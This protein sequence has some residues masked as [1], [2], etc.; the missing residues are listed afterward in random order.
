MRGARM[1]SVQTLP[2]IPDRRH[3]FT[4]AA[5]SSGSSNCDPI[6][7]LSIACEPPNSQSLSYGHEYFFEVQKALDPYFLCR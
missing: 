6:A 1:K 4:G 3:R 7:L 2:E 5:G